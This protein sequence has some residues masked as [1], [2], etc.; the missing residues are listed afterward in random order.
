MIRV[1]GRELESVID[2]EGLR[3]VL[4][5]QGCSH[6]CLG[7]Q[8]PDTHAFDGGELM[9]EQEILDEVDKDPILDGVTLSGGDPFFQAD[10][11]IPMCE[12]WRKRGLD[13]WA[14]TGFKFE[15]FLNFI[16]KESCSKKV[17]DDMIKLL[18][19]LDVVVD[20]PFVLSK[21]TMEKAYVGSSNQ[22]LVDVKKSLANN[23]VIL[24]E[25]E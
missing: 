13:L 21:K 7:C 5:M 23:K 22:R 15:E 14:Y 18:E 24:Y 8:N 3:Y 2:G 6:N 12:H 11:L 10:K 9:D 25:L 4:F 17:T 16:N 19:Y 20:G 1:A